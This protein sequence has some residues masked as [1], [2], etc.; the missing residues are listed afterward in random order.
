MSET[1]HERVSIRGY[2]IDGPT[3]DP[4]VQLFIDYPD[5]TGADVP[6]RSAALVAD[7]I[8]LVGTQDNVVSTVS[9]LT[10]KVTTTL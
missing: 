5:M 4:I 3:G 8:A 1:A 6:A 2:S 7:I 9:I 10:D